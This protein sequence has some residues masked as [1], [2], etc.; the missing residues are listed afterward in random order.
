MT[1]EELAQS[2]TKYIET[3][4]MVTRSELYKKLGT[5]NHVLDRLQGK[6]LCAVPRLLSRKE[7]VALSKKKGSFDNFKRS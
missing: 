2:V 5:T 1:D 7:V 6:G 4:K 3:H